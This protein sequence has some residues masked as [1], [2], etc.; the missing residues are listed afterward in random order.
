MVI[1]NSYFCS[2]I[3]TNY[4]CELFLNAK[5][6]TLTISAKNSPSDA[7]MSVVVRGTKNGSASTFEGAVD[8]NGRSYHVFTLPTDFT[9]IASVELRFNRK[10][11]PYTDKTTEFAD[12]QLELSGSKTEYEPY[13]E[14][15]TV[16]VNVDGTAS[17]SGNGESITLIT[18]TDGITITAEY[19]K[20]LNKAF[21][22]IY[23][24][25]AHLGAAAVTIP[26][27]V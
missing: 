3:N 7:R 18:D 10:G 15:E 27:E 17:I 12:F 23:Q 14:P 6:K 25:I 2:I 13:K 19:N 4:L 11:N 9:T 21:A 20:D 1:N 22:E 16:Q 8:T 5:G 24:A 26:E